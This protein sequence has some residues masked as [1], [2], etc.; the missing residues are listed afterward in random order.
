MLPGGRG[1]G[2]H[3]ENG[4]G[5]AL[6][7]LGVGFSSLSLLIALRPDYVKL[8]R[9]L[10][11]DVDT[12]AGKALIARK[13]LEVARELGLSAVAEGIERP[14][15]WDWVRQHGAYFVQGYLFVRPDR[16]PPLRA[17]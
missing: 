4:F 14:E 10:I 8:D 12:D 13:L 5:V 1:S 9:S 16:S 15:E 7:D 17:V 6:D 2:Y 3:K 11:Q